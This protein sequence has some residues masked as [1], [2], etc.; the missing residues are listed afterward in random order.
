MGKLREASS[1]AGGGEGA[2]H[3]NDSG[4]KSTGKKANFDQEM[5]PEDASRSEQGVA[6]IRRYR[7]M[8]KTGGDQQKQNDRPYLR[9]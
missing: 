6:A 3:R 1:A 5:K 2:D 4:I 7:K 9:R 8:Q